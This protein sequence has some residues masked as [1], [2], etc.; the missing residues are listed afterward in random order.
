MW[1]WR[2]MALPRR[3]R[4]LRHLSH[5]RSAAEASTFL[6]RWKARTDGCAPFFTRD[7]LPASVAALSAHDSTPQPSPRQ[8]GSGR[9]RKAPR[10]VDPHLRYAQVHKRRAGGRGVEVQRPSL[11]GSEDDLIQILATDGCGAQLHTSSRERDNLTS[12]HSHGRLVRQTLSHAKK[13]V[14]RQRHIDL[15]EAIYHCIRPQSALKVK[16]RHPAAHGRRWQ[17]RP[18]AIAAGLTDHIWSLEELLS[19]CEPPLSGYVGG[20]NVWHLLRCLHMECLVR[21]KTCEHRFDRLRYTLERGLSRT[22]EP[23][24]C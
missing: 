16:L 21:A 18:P 11:C 20:Q 13:K 23:G 19:Y 7:Q 15:E 12:R 8:R 14:Y 2:A 17:Q 6:A 22:R 24:V 10:G 3:W 1:G 4:V 9:P 5:E